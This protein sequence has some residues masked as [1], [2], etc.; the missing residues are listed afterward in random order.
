MLYAKQYGEIR[1]TSCA[2]YKAN[3][4]KIKIK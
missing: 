3:W 4:I 2:E 1:D